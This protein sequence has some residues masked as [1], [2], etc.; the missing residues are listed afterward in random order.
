MKS[1]IFSLPFFLTLDL[2]LNFD[3]TVL[4]G[5]NIY[6]VN[7]KCEV[8]PL[9]YDFKDVEDFVSSES[10]RKL[11]GV[12]D[13]QWQSCSMDVHQHFTGDFMRGFAPVVKELLEGD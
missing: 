4:T 12:G 9:C 8:P 2:T 6:N 13:I 11:L 10:T 7:E 5:W 1:T 3:I